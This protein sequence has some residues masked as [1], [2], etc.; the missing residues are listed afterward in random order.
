V[1]SMRI[2]NSAIATMHRMRTILALDH[3]GCQY[4]SDQRHCQPFLLRVEIKVFRARPLELDMRCGPRGGNSTLVTGRDQRVRTGPESG[5]MSL[6]AANHK[7]L[8]SGRTTQARNSPDQAQPHA[9]RPRRLG[10]PHLKAP[11]PTHSHRHRQCP[12]HAPAPPPPAGIGDAL[13]LFF[14]AFNRESYR[15]VTSDE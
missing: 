4:T 9:A 2:G 8:S 5:K 12:L 11:V 6:S 15:L 1:F 7:G 3:G 10:V 13:L 14:P